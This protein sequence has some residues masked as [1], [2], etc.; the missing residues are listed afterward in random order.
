MLAGM[1]SRQFGEWQAFFELEPFGSRWKD[2]RAG[3][4]AAVVRNA[5]LA[6]AGGKSR[7]LNAEDVMPTPDA[8]ERKRQNEAR[9]KAAMAERRRKG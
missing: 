4:V 1:T 6:A 3:Q 8:T 5:T 2:L 9:L 7:P